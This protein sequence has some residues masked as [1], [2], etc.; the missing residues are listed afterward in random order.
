MI[1]NITK[2]ILQYGQDIT[3]KIN[4]NINNTQEI[5]NTKSIIQALRSDFQSDLYG[6]YQDTNNNNTEQ[7]LYIGPSNI[8]LTNLIKNNNII[9]NTNSEDYIIKKIEQV[10]LSGDCVY[11][12]GVLEKNTNV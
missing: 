9:I 6:D 1:I 3:I 10:F 7:Y 12:R 2:L 4:N 8:N 11:E 5:I